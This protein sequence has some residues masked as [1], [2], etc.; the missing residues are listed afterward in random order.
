MEDKK[1]AVFGIYS[2]NDAGGESGR[3]SGTGGISQ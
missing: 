2:V 3:H 1:T